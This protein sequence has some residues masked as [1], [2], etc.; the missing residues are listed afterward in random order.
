MRIS[1]LLF[2]LISMILQAKALEVILDPY[3]GLDYSEPQSYTYNDE[4]GCECVCHGY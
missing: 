2:I 3:I 1:I 4:T